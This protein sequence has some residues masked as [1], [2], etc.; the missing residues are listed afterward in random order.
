VLQYGLPVLLAVVGWSGQLLMSPRSDR[1]T[2]EEMAQA[3]QALARRGLEWW[4][5][6]PEPAWPGHVLRA[7]L[8]PLDVQWAPGGA[9]DDG[10]VYGRTS[11][12]EGLAAR[13]RDTRPC[14]LVICGDAGSG[15]SV[16]A[17]LLM[18][19]LL[20]NRGP[21][22]PVPVFLPLW[23]WDPGR[24]HLNDWMKRRIRGAYPE[25]EEEA[26]YG[27]TAIAALVDQGLVLPILDGLDALPEQCRT[28]V[29]TDGG[30]RSQEQLILTCRTPVFDK[31]FA[32]QSR[33]I[34]GFTVIEP[35]PVRYAEAERF[36]SDVTGRSCA[37]KKVQA[38][39][40]DG[41][42]VHLK[43]ALREPRITYL[44]SSV[45]G[46]EDETF[47]TAAAVALMTNCGDQSPA[48]HELIE[49]NEDPSRAVRTQL[50]ASLIPALMPKGG[51]WARTFPW[52]ADSAEEWLRSLARLDLRDAPGAGPYLAP[53][54]GG[55]EDPGQQPEPAEGPGQQ[56]YPGED[57]GSSRIAWWNLYRGI[58]LLRDH[59]APLR[60]LAAG[61]IAVGV[62]ACIFRFRHDWPYSLM[63]AAAYGVLIFT[64][65]AFLGRATADPPGI[66]SPGDS[67][68]GAIWWSVRYAYAHYG[69]I[70]AAGFISF[71]LFG[72]LIGAREVV[73]PTS[74]VKSASML[75]SI[76]IRTG[77]YDGLAQGF[78][79]L[80][81]TFVVAGVPAAP[82]TVRA[83]DFS[84]RPR[85]EARAFATAVILGI[86]FG[87][88]WG[89]T[90][91]LKAQHPSQVLGYAE[92]IPTALITGVDFALGSWLFRWSRRLF[93]PARSS[94]PRSAA[95]TDLAG[96]LLRPLILAV[97][98][99]FGFGISAPSKMTSPGHV[100]RTSISLPVHITP[101]D[102]WAWFV[103][104]LILGS[105]ESE[106]PLYMTSV[107]WLALLRKKTKGRLPLRLMRFL[108]CCRACGIL[109]V[110]GQ[111]Y[112]IHDVDLLQYLATPSPDRGSGPADGETSSERP[113][114]TGQA[115]V[116]SVRPG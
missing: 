101:V 105:L 8:R 58:G 65:C 3:L 45:L 24:E 37:W 80:V 48:I 70:A 7:G 5:G 59:Q 68:R 14:R 86:A 39:I 82:R 43:Q 79:L 62:I 73:A 41:S 33:K 27:P 104:G 17:R 19:E 1:S 11:H 12:L 28:P 34:E 71:C 93:T 107:T 2:P 30:L 32:D 114:R 109:R 77:F 55:H 6:V 20:K 108:E 94:S 116:A 97:T 67:R 26:A 100:H 22:D 64:G 36:L 9:P 47:G 54:D 50:L 31:A 90:V 13:F 98:F 40:N 103:V 51:D 52:Y 84:H 60:G 69:R 29:V 46:T 91:V 75:T 21:A 66:R 113:E 87:I 10:P 112:Q 95:R 76:A 15:K 111:E 57:P 72:I 99:A 115:K 4:R 92:A 63:T 96:A 16:L 106:W 35:R 74:T 42:H 85:P 102:L 38:G 88:V 89:V 49:K 56:V 78:L 25:L 18:A 44:A 83:S 110:V 61:S 53:P 23:S 81:L